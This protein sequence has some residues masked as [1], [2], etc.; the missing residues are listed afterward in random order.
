MSTD[1]RILG[2]MARRGVAPD[3]GGRVMAHDRGMQFA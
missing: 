2:P 3:L 1:S